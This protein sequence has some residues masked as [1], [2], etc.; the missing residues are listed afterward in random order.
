MRRFSTALF[1]AIVCFS[2]QHASAQVFEGD[3][4]LFLDAGFLTWSSDRYKADTAGGDLKHT[5]NTTSLGIL[6][7][8]GV[9][10]GYALR[11]WLIPELYF[12]LNH[13]KT[14]SKNRLEGDEIAEE[15]S[16]SRSWEL[17]PM[18][19]FPI[20]PEGRV[21]PFA[22]AGLSL[23]REVQKSDGSDDSSRFLYGPY[24][25]GGIHGFVPKGISF[26]FALGFRTL[27]VKDEDREEALEGNGWDD[28]RQRQLD[29][30]LTFG[31]SFWL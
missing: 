6:G 18:V 13:A 24:I 15:K 10:A 12:S 22:A 17:R 21:V 20:L 2:S 23:G 5:D 19:E 1:I 27:F 29:L 28:I 14:R 31:V 30:L 8:G 7:S 26:D 25:G 16:A 3:A 11:S 9:G 4:R